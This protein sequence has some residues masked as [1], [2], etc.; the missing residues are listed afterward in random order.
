MLN[1]IRTKFGCWLMK[2][3]DGEIQKFNKTGNLKYIK[4][5]LN[6]LN[7]ALGVLPASWEKVWF[8]IS[9]LEIIEKMKK[10]MEA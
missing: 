1:R 4:R 5:G 9:L 8:T 2:V 7:G 10:G 6:I 3:A